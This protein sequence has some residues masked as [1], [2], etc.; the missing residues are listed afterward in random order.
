M[1]LGTQLSVLY[2]ET[3]VCLIDPNGLDL[4]VRVKDIPKELKKRTVNKLGRA[5]SDLPYNFL[6]M[7]KV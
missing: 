5:S 4:V 2:P 7:L 1:K 3:I 6:I